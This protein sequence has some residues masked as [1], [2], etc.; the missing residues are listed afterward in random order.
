[1]INEER[2]P[3]KLFQALLNRYACKPAHGGNV[4][5][6]VK[7][8][9]I[10]LA[11]AVAASVASLAI[12]ALAQHGLGGS[13]GGGKGKAAGHVRAAEELVRRVELL[14]KRLNDLIVKY[15]IT[16]P[17]NLSS[18]LE[19]AKELIS[20]ASLM[21]NSSPKEAIK[22]AI[23]AARASAPVAVYVIK[24]LPPNV[25]HELFRERVNATIT[26]E[27]RAAGRAE[28]VIKWLRSRS[29]PVPPQAAALIH[30][31][32]TLLKKA[33]E[34]LSKGSLKSAVELSRRAGAE[35]GMAL[36][37]MRR[38]AGID[39]LAA[40]ATDL[41]IKHLVVS[42]SRICLMINKSI[43]MLEEGNTSVAKELLIKAYHESTHLMV[44]IKVIAHRLAGVAPPAK[45][46]RNVTKVFRLSYEV[47]KALSVSINESLKYVTA[48]NVSG[49]EEVLSKALSL[50]NPLMS[51]LTETARWAHGILARV[52]A[53]MGRVEDRL[54]VM[55]RRHA[56][57]MPHP[58]IPLKN[59]PRIIK[60]IKYRVEKAYKL[61]SNGSIS[62]G[63]YRAVLVKADHA[64][65]AILNA[66]RHAPV[67]PPKKLVNEVVSLLKFVESQ[68]S[69][70][71]GHGHMI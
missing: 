22:L 37:I 20:N 69:S 51:N 59:L 2:V 34:L 60:V 47:L 9:S 31:S 13:R 24:S 26:M 66:L 7:T 71:K 28:E 27:L 57:L 12:P 40:T 8:A 49:A 43:T 65:H 18:R 32:I 58:P 64:L 4:K 46:P 68:L 23:K 29:V 35:L 10:I 67:K 63:R 70:L 44:R 30:H 3:L 48:G 45:V 6:W 16:L 36:M 52:R 62:I 17:G 25:R 54:T 55:I 11:I 50:V 41:I 15:N 33:E 56:P 21:I 19:L 61:Y 42:T 38:E 5:P 39:W 53:V 1:M 14:I